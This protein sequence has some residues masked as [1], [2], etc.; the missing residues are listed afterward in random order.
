[1]TKRLRFCLTDF[2]MISERHQWSWLGRS[3]TNHQCSMM[4]E[5]HWTS[6]RPIAQTSQKWVLC[7]LLDFDFFGRWWQR[8]LWILISTLKICW[9]SFSHFQQ[10]PLWKTGML[11]CLK[12]WIWFAELCWKKQFQ[13][14]LQCQLFTESKASCGF[15]TRSG[16]KSSLWM[17]LV[18][19]DSI[20]QWRVAR[21]SLYLAK[22]LS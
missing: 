15:Y 21:E 4:F 8:L 11:C 3:W 5:I 19:V 18:R 20:N 6:W 16:K 17:T 13:R 2:D 22:N 10:K 14:D 1:M 12:R 7:Y 9:M